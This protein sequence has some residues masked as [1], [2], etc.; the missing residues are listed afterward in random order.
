LTESNPLLYQALTVNQSAGMQF[1]LNNNTAAT[2]VPSQVQM[3]IYD[4]SGNLVFRL[5]AN[6]GQP[7]VSG[8]AYLTAGTY[9]VC[10]AAVAQDGAAAPA[11]NYSLY[12]DVLSDPIGPEILPSSTPTTTTPVSTWSDPSTMAL[13]LLPA[14]GALLYQ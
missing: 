13:G 3:L 12:T 1:V 7:A 9:T 8:V 14:G 5:T 6:S 4:Q 10:F 2:A 11:L